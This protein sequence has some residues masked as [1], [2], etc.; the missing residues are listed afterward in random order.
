LENDDIEFM[1]KINKQMENYCSLMDKGCLR[2]ALRT[3]I[4]ISAEGNIYF[5]KVAPWKCIKDN[6]IRADTSIVLG[7]NLIHILSCLSSPFMPTLSDELNIQLNSSENC[8]DFTYGIEIKSG[9]M[10]SKDI[11][12]LIPSITKEQKESFIDK[13]GNK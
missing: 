3:V 1:N 9:H 5:N 13:F 8:F 11:K 4:D 10:I 6:K 7:C 2:D 12:P